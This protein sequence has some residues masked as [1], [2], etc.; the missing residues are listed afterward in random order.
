MQAAFLAISANFSTIQWPSNRFWICR[1][2]LLC[3]AIELRLV[4]K[5]AIN[6]A[7]IAPF[8]E[9]LE[10]LVDGVA[11]GNVEK[12][13]W[14]PKTIGTPLRSRSTICEPSRLSVSLSISEVV[15][16]LVLSLTQ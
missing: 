12:I 9:A 14:R 10:R 15:T 13:T 5:A 11:P 1:A 2:V 3:E 6:A 8:D 16:R 4:V 7:K